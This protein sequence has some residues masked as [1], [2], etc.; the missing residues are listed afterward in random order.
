MSRLVDVNSR[1]KKHKDN[2]VRSASKA[3]FIV[4]LCGPAMASKTPPA[5]LRERL[6]K[7][8]TSHGIDVVLGEDD[9]L[10]DA[11]LGLSVNAQDNELEFIRSH[12]NAV[13]IIA[14]S[15]GSFCEL[16]LFSWHCV[17]EDGVISADMIVLIDKEYSNAKSYLNQGPVAAVHG[18][19]QAL[20]VDFDAYDGDDVVTRLLSR[21]ATSIMDRR[22]KPRGK[23]K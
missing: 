10:E 3:P 14:A 16:G 4:F 7:Q 18:F 8:L 12:C 17:H 19:G 20:F 6:R 9:G 5:I 21:R 2:L 15:V 11:R 23:K 1:I 22:G 13:V